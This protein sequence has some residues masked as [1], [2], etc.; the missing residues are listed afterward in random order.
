MTS[1]IILILLLHIYITF[2]TQPIARMTYSE[3]LEIS[4]TDKDYLKF[5]LIVTD[6]P[7]EDWTLTE[8][9]HRIFRE[10]GPIF[11]SNTQQINCSCI[12]ADDIRTKNV[13]NEFVSTFLYEK[14]DEDS[15]FEYWQ[16]YEPNYNQYKA[17]E[18]CMT[19]TDPTYEI[20][21]IIEEFNNKSQNNDNQCIISPENDGKIIKKR[22]TYFR[23]MDLSEEY[24]KFDAI[25]LNILDHIRLSHFFK[26]FNASQR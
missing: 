5:P 16:K 4:K 18:D 22:Y 25:Q 7:I 2:G 3:L 8:N 10:K 12:K 9:I 26:L 24:S 13:C 17:F 14:Y 21:D 6:S 23:L 1:P 11:N 19:Y 20:K 15:T